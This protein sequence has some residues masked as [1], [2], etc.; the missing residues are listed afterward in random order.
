MRL[1]RFLLLPERARSDTG[2]KGR[3]GD[4]IAVAEPWF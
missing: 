3:P 4:H 2:G 1:C